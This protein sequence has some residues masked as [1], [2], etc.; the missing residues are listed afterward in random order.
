MEPR[1]QKPN[2]STGPFISTG[3]PSPSQSSGTGGFG[4]PAYDASSAPPAPP[5]AIGYDPDYSPG[6]PLTPLRG[7]RGANIVG[8][9]LAVAALAIIVAAVAFIVSQFRENGGGDNK[10]APTAVVAVV[11]GSPTETTDQGA[12]SEETPTTEDVTPAEDAKPTRTPKVSRPTTDPNEDLD[13]TEVPTDEPSN[14]GE[15]TKA[16]Q[17]FPK[18]SDIGGGFVRTDNGTRTEEEVVASFPVDQQADAPG[19]L[20]DFGWQ[21]NAY[22]EYSNDSAA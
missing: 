1:P 14:T 16:S 7:P 2:R 3:T 4:Q 20:A 12:T 13:A 10:N 9:L 6:Q 8:P 21:E 19:K 18:E 17:W 5:P 15:K 11:D 22:R